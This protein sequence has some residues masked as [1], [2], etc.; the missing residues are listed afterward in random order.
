MSRKN[1]KFLWLAALL[2]L[3]L[4]AGGCAA[5][6]MPT[7]EPADFSVDI[8]VPYAT[9]TPAPEQANQNVNNGPF[10]IDANGN[11]TLIDT[12]WIDSGF[13][14]SSLG[15]Q[16]TYYT[17]LRLGDSGVEVR[18]LQNRLKE[19]A[20]Y[21]GDVSGVFDAGT[22]DAVKL[23]ELS[24]GSMQTGIA[25]ARMQT[26]LFAASAPAYNSSAYR[27]AI[28]GDYETLQSGDTGASVYA[29]QER[30]IELGY[31]LREATGIFDE[32]TAN[33]VRLFYKAYKLDESDIAVVA[34]QKEL[35]SDSARAYSGSEG[36][37]QYTLSVGN[38]GTLVTE[39][40]ERLIEL[41]YMV[42]EASGS[43]DENTAE[44]VRLAQ[45][46]IGQEETGEANPGLQNML[47]NGDIPAA[48]DTLEDSEDVLRQGSTGE[49]VALLQQRL[50]E[51]GYPDVTATGT[52]DDA[53][54]HAVS[55][56]Q[57]SANLEQTGTASEALQAYIFSEN[58]QPY[59]ATEELIGSEDEPA[60]LY[61]LG[62]SGE[63]VTDLQNR[64]QEL[65]YL[66]GKVTGLYDIDTENA[67]KAFQ[68]AIGVPQTGTVSATLALY[69]PS[70]AAPGPKITFYD[71]TPPAYTRLA[72]GDS[73]EAV[74]S[75]QK[76]LWERGFLSREGVEDSVGVY[77]E[78]TQQAVTDAQIMMG[79]KTTD[80]I[81]G[82][83]F[84]AFLF[85]KY[86]DRLNPAAE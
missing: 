9:T 29:L 58:A 32:E 60:A 68:A 85:S 7:S 56:L 61:A 48:G 73:G 19:L 23:F 26:L 31:P 20:Y 6:D 4:A 74:T 62:A 15:D 35:F 47:A 75:L 76:R 80:G 37:I 30:L 63:G 3:C 52:F 57:G 53:T 65:G 86:G 21:T 49:A 14:A 5:V 51:L 78:A 59:R 64:L 46:A 84:Q 36:S 67:V 2:A 17:Q 83:E 41:G 71:G 24:Y 1:S 54:A 40:Q 27:S 66:K 42:G 72:L 43:Y 45:R 38:I 77:N 12:A 22:E 13:A 50:I 18:N 79:Y 28:T 81:A 34:L 10:S 33:A 44:A 70:N 82:V 69:L 39:L 8:V 16:E 25:T 55:L 11:V